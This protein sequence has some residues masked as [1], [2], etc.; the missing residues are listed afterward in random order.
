[1]NK[2]LW[3]SSVAI[4]AITG[5]GLL[6]N[7]AQAFTLSTTLIGDPRLDNPDHLFVQVKIQGGASAGL[8]ANEALFTVNINSPEH[9]DVKL[10]EFYFNLADSIKSFVTFSDFSPVSAVGN[11]TWEVYSPANNANGSGG[12]D[13]HFGV[14]KAQKGGR[15]DQRT[16]DVT[17]SVNLTF[18]L[19]SSAGAL[20]AGDFLD[21]PFSASNDALLGSGQ[22]GAHLQ[23]L[24]VNSTTCPEGGCSDSGFVIG[25][26]P[27]PALLPGLLGLGVAALRKKQQGSVEEEA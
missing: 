20:K 7:P 3:S 16:P 21:A 10:D 18:K 2:T 13:F 5:V 19:I 1:M 23:A 26:V 4:A 17:N 6:S 8:N 14:R 9:D 25:E 15:P 12:A 22:L 11:N 24:T 27:T